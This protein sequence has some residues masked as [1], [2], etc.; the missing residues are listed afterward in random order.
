MWC[1]ATAE[2]VTNGEIKSGWHK[3]DIVKNGNDDDSTNSTRT[4]MWYEVCVVDQIPK[5]IQQ[6]GMKGLKQNLETSK[7]SIKK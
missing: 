3:V 5:I 1:G 7:T 4:T 6:S 2:E